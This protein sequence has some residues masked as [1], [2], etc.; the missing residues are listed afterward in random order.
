M[1]GQNI[2]Y[3]QGILTFQMNIDAAF[4]KLNPGLNKSFSIKKFFSVIWYIKL[5]WK[6]IC[7]FKVQHFDTNSPPH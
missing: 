7:F 1:I 2:I 6:G 3:F 5:K 4:N